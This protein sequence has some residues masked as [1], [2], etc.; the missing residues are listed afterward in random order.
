[1]NEDRIKCES[2]PA[3]AFDDHPLAFDEMFEV[4]QVE[5]EVYQMVREMDGVPIH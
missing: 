1:L 4:K 3:T 5:V 2:S